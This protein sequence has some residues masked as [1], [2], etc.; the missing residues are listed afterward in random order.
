[1]QITGR[2]GSVKLKLLLRR[3]ERLLMSGS[4]RR[5]CLTHA[6]P[7]ARCLGLAFGPRQHLRQQ[8]VSDF[9]VS[10][11]NVEHLAEYGAVLLTADQH[12]LQCA[13]HVELSIDPHQL[14]RTLRHGDARSINGHTRTAQRAAK[15]AQVT[16]EFAGAGIAEDRVAP[17]W[18]ARFSRGHV[19]P[20]SSRRVPTPRQ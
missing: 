6:R 3:G 5:Q 14:Q 10:E 19:R 16:R 12:G 20:L 1:M 17:R 18:L 11:K 15:G 7:L 8:L 9:R 13:A 4:V 2:H